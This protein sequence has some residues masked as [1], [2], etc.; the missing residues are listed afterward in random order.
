MP[1]IKTNKGALKRFRVT[2]KGNLKRSKAYKRHILTSKN[3]KRK[4]GLTVQGYVNESDLK[5]MKRLLPSSF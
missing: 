4:R 5:R 1:K 3:A 2:S